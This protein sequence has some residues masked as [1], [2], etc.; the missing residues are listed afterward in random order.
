MSKKPSKVDLLFASWSA[1]ILIVAAGHRADAQGISEMGAIYSMPKPMPG[2][3]TTGAIQNLYSMPGF[4]GG[5]GAP[6][7]A[8]AGNS[9]GDNQKIAAAYAKQANALFGT[10]KQKEKAGKIDEAISLYKQSA[11]IRERVWGLKDTSLYVIYKLI[12]DLSMKQ[13]KFADAEAAYRKMHQVG[14]KSYGTGAYELVPVL[15]CLGDAISAQGKHHDG[16]NYYKQVYHLNKRKLGDASPQTAAGAI[17]LSGALK[18]AGQKE[19]ARQTLEDCLKGAE[20]GGDSLV[21][22]RLREAVAAHSEEG[23]ISRSNA[24]GQSSGGS[25]GGGSSAGGTA[26]GE[27]TPGGSQAGGS[28]PAD[29]VSGTSD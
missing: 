24:G 9:V 7:A 3:G 13:K 5:A 12:G 23:A 8:G 22:E 27:S 4:P 21:V 20:K 15:E 1:C 14:M 2:Q 10:A 18:A 25:S 6:R 19:A 17:K 11:Q 26:P 28:L 16:A 29:Q